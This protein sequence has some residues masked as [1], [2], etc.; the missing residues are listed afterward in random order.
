[1]CAPNVGS[2]MIGSPT[3][4]TWAPAAVASAIIASTR[5]GVDVDPEVRAE[6]GHLAVRQEPLP[7]VPAEHHDDELRVVLTELL[8]ERRG[9]VE[10]TLVGKPGV[11]DRLLQD[12]HPRVGADLV[13]EAEAEVFAD[14][15]TEL[16]DRQRFRH[17]R[18]LERG[19]TQGLLRRRLVVS[20]LR[21]LRRRRRRDHGPPGRSVVRPAESAVAAVHDPVETEELLHARDRAQDRHRHAAPHAERRGV[22]RVVELARV[23]TRPQ[24]EADQPDREGVTG[25]HDAPPLGGVATG[26]SRLAPTR[27]R[28]SLSARHR[29]RRAAFS[30][31]PASQAP[32]RRASASV[33]QR[34]ALH[35]PT[36]A[37][38]SGSR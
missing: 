4:S 27:T 22:R 6:G 9:P 14:R 34:F 23:E 26:R 38:R 25:R 33:R 3:H 16:E 10:V 36:S 37:P 21:P 7:V 30:A 13:G 24:R 29:R 2:C 19:W 15:V 32:S 5:L 11:A 1:M 28:K 17:R 8:L 35:V 20:A 12:V 31:S 18:R